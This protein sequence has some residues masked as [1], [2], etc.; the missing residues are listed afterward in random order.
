MQQN[1]KKLEGSSLYLGLAL[2]SFTSLLTGLPVLAQPIVPANDTTGTLVNQNGDRID[3]SGG[4]LSGDGRNLFHSFSQF[5]LDA[6][7][8]ANFLSNPNI[9]NILG[10]INGGSPSF[11][12]G[13]LQVLGGQSNLFLLNPYGIVFG[14]NAQLNIPGSFN[15]STATG[16]GFDN[17]HWFN[18]FGSNDYHSLIGNPNSFAFSSL[19]PGAIINLGHLAVNSGQNL[20]L[21]GGTVVSNGQIS[22][23]KAKLL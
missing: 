21:L 16:I 18:A 4:K 15:A 17:N 8:T 14:S 3:I 12:N 11:I 2:A 5:G 9:H 7:Q 13:L 19:Q 1:L 10:R 23:P 6:N 20:T 22:A